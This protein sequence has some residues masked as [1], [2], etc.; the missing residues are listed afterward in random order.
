M[1]LKKT[2]LIKKN[3]EEVEEM[4]TVKSNFLGLSLIALDFSLVIFNLYQ[5]AHLI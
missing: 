1:H 4:E 2:L 3:F 5:L